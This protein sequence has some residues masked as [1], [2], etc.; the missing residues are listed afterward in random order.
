MSINIR[1][2]KLEYID[3]WIKG[4]CD[5]VKIFFVDA[6]TMELLSMRMIQLPLLKDVREVLRRQVCYDRESIDRLIDN[7]IDT[8]TIQ[9]MASNAYKIVHFDKEKNEL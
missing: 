1:K 2:M 6:D 4:N 3:R 7:A 8:Y 5:N 9:Y